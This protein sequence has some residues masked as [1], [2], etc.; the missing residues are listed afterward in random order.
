MSHSCFQ[1]LVSA[2][3]YDG[4]YSSRSSSMDATFDSSKGALLSQNEGYEPLS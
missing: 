3:E 4:Q 1:N 2:P